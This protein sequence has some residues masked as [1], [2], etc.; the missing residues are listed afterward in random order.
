MAISGNGIQVDYTGLY[1]INISIQLDKSGGGIDSCDFWLRVNG[2]DV[3]DS[4][5]QVTIQ[6]NTGECLANVPFFLSLNALDV[7]EIVIASPDNTMTATAFPAWV[8][9][10]DP[11]DRPAIPSVIMNVKLIK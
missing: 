3:A 4:A 7:F 2:N 9:P 5:S 10:G 1:E 6:G 8:T 11:Y